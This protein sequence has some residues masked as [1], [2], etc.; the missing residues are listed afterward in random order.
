MSDMRTPSRFLYD[1]MAEPDLYDA[2][3]AKR[4]VAFFIDAFLVVALMIPAALMVVLVGT[5][6]MQ[7]GRG[8]MVVRLFVAA[9]LLWLTLLLGLGSLDPM[10]RSDY[11]VQ[12]AHPQ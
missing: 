9:G 5:M 8:P 2:I 6:F 11:P 3:L 12:A 7:V 4:V 1:P 10:T